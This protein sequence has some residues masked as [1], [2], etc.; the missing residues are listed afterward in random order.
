MRSATDVV[1]TTWEAAT[2]TSTVSDAPT[3][4]DLPVRAGVLGVGFAPVGPGTPAAS[5]SDIADRV[6]R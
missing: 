4:Q 2:T 6:N 5:K 1:V 3:P